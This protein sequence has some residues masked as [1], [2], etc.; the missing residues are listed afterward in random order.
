MLA[1][2]L[3][4]APLSMAAMSTAT[5]STAEASIA[6]ESIAAVSVP[7]VSPMAAP[8]GKPLMRSWG[9]AEYHGNLQN[10]AVEQGP[11]GRI[12]VG[13]GMGLQIFDGA[14]WTRIPTRHESRVRDLAIE[15]DGRVWIGSSNE[16]G[17]FE[18][19][20][21]GGMAYHSLSDRLPADQ[22]AFG[23]IRSLHRLDGKVYFH[24]HQAVFRWNGE[25]L[26]RVARWDGVFRIALVHRQRLL[27]L[28]GEHFH[29]LTDPPA[30]NAAP[31]PVFDLVLPPQARLTLLE[32]FADGR[33]LLGTYAHGLY[34]L[35][36]DGLQRFVT[37]APLEGSWPVEVLPL[38]DGG[39]LLG[40][41][42]G[43][44]LH[45]DADG[46]LLDHVTR[47]SGLPGDAI[48][49]LALD[50]EGGVWLAQNAA[51]TRVALFN[52]VR[53]YDADHGVVN[54]REILR[55][56]DR[57]LVAGGNGVGVLEPDGSD[58]SRLH[59]LPSPVIEA[60]DLLTSGEDVLVSGNEGV[61]RMRL[62]LDARRVLSSERLLADAF[63]Y[64]LIRS[65]FRDA[66]Y[67]ELENGLGVLLRENGTW[68]AVPHVAGIDQRPHT[69]VEDE[70]GRVWVGTVAGR[71][72][73]LVWR[74]ATTL[75]VDAVFD[76]EQ[77]VPEGYAWAFE[78]DGDVALGTT[79]GGFR[80]AADGTRIEPDPAFGN[81]Q[82]GGPPPG[83]WRAVYRLYAADADTVIGGIGPGGALWL[84]RRSDDRSLHWQRWLAQLEAAQN[85]VIRSM[86]GQVWIGRYPGLFRIDWPPVAAPATASQ[87]HVDRIGYA[88]SDDWLR[89]GPLAASGL[90][91]LPLPF[92]SETLRF[93]YALA[94]FTAPELTEYRVRLDGLDRDWSRWSRETRRDYSNLSG[95][96]YR[97]QVEARNVRG[98]VVAAP[99]IAFSIKPP[100]FLSR[101][102]LAAYVLGALALLVLAA[103][104]GQRVRVRRLRQ[105]QR[106]LER[107]V[108]ERTAEVRAQA[109]KIR[110]ISDARAEFF[111]NVS[112]ELRTPLTL[113]RAPLQELARGAAGPLGEQA[114]RHVETALRNS[115]AM[116]SLIG[117]VLDLQ[118]LDAGA[119]PLNLQPGDLAVLVRIIVDRFALHAR[120]RGVELSSAG[121]DGS[122][123]GVFDVAH[124]DTVVGNLVSN[125]LKFT[126]RGG[127]VTVRLRHPGG[128]F[129]IEVADTGPGI[130]PADHQRIFER[131]QQ[132]TQTDPSQ[133]GTGIGLALVRELVALHGGRVDVDSVPGAGAR[134]TVRI[135]DALEAGA[136][137]A[138]IDASAGAEPRPPSMDA[139][140]ARDAEM[141]TEAAD[142]DADSER[143]CVLIV[144]DNAELRDFLRVR[145]GRSYRIVEASDGEEGLAL[146][147]A[148]VPDVV[149]TD[150]MMP[151][152]GGLAL[153]AAIK[154]DPELDF[155][156]VLMLSARAG[157]DDTVRG[158]QAGADDYLAKPFDGAELAARVAALIASRRRLRERLHAQVEPPVATESAFVRQ[159]DAV[160]AGHLAD[161]EFSVRDWAQLM[162]MD[163]TTLF[164][165]LKSETGQSPEDY[166]REQ[167]LQHAARLLAERA[168]TV[169]EVAD[170][171]GFASVSHFSRRFRERFDCTP[172]GFAKR[173][174]AREPPSRWANPDPNGV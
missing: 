41:Q 1:L 125:A 8:P 149:V 73:R 9:M 159:A 142:A 65:R 47:R 5:Q 42:H 66:V 164:R 3:G 107:E 46:R 147:R 56:H 6:A 103:A 131:Y 30:G 36:E 148:H 110:R 64:E 123:R 33:M 69:V 43:G 49:A 134:F 106:R 126:P 53:L 156:P 160:L 89:L 19:A 23:D 174:G 163:R 115:E 38:D 18:A 10:W 11:D 161:P 17:W 77:G 109:Q 173:Q 4:M 83:N 157:K 16:F 85:N 91:D 145:L 45:L 99:A 117:Q 120:S 76:R 79:Q 51:I 151:R 72:Y 121:A 150:G 14:D 26:D 146:A 98:E 130:D 141:E 78:L 158:L 48:S 154:T 75:A 68:R 102:A 96:E 62:D 28:V 116:Q 59:V 101:A 70:H 2:S 95:G 124:L 100:W 93:E 87:L 172:A 40:T 24:S 113:T 122:M 57:L 55:H 37:D 105:T 20:A 171:V 135:P 12:F 165:K 88:D 139:V 35:D 111:A 50:H 86:D 97:F 114:R 108:A 92:R 153:T 136:H 82:F 29:D 21:D 84:G 54:A 112:H 74:D 168:G 32:P 44:L 15:P 119:L 144:D 58:S 140:D 39:L 31:D 52:G 162:H 90:S 129:E 133:P 118:R 152:M 94:S 155:V 170:A 25:R 132:G 167:R 63:G 138:P 13:G 67:A 143:P 60:F 71:F 137:A 22:R 80:L 34:W 81:A 27:V 169:A 166:V 104:L 127:S 61:H 128:H 7:A